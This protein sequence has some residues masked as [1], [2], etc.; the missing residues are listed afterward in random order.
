MAKTFLIN[1][2]DKLYVRKQVQDESNTGLG[3][4][5]LKKQVDW[6]LNLE[7]D[8]SIKFPSISELFF[9]YE[10]SFGYYDMTFKD[11]ATLRDHII[12]HQIVD[13]NIENILKEAIQFCAGINKSQKMS[14]SKEDALKYLNNQHLLKMVKRCDIVKKKSPT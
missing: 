11:M 3:L 7:K 12:K 4:D 8:I 13:E 5:K 6:I 1:K 2:N 10:N 14:I 9:D